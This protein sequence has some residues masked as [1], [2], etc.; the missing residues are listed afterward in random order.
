MSTRDVRAVVQE[1]VLA[2]VQAEDLPRDA[3]ADMHDA[4]EHVIQ[5]NGLLGLGNCRYHTRLPH[6]TGRDRLLGDRGRIRAYFLQALIQLDC[7]RVR[8]RDGVL[9][10][11][12]RH[13]HIRGAAHDPAGDLVQQRKRRMT[14]QRYIP[15]RVS[16]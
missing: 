4:L 6:P 15:K 1:A 5:A 16:R 8:G 14:R 12:L 13:L 10:L 9:Q 11:G 3:N 2:V 7:D